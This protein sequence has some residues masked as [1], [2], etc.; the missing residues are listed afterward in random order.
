MTIESFIEDPQSGEQAVYRRYNQPK[1]GH[2][3]T[4]Y[5]EGT[6]GRF[7]AFVVGSKRSDVADVYE[8]TDGSTLELGFDAN[9]LPKDVLHTVVTADAPYEKTIVAPT[10]QEGIL[11]VRS[12]GSTA[13]S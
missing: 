13:L 1:S 3:Y 11:R 9:A 7:T 2:V 4:S 5:P 8:I 6:G 10:G 12:V